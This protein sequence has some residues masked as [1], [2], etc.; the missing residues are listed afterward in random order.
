[1]KYRFAMKYLP[2]ANV[3]V[4]VATLLIIIKKKYT[5]PAEIRNEVVGNTLECS[6]SNR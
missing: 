5:V 1:M 2:A 6:G 4:V 3:K